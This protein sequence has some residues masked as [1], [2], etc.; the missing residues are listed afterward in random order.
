[1]L[2]LMKHKKFQNYSQ[3]YVALLMKA[4]PLTGRFILTGSSSPE[5]L[6]NI[7]ESLAGRIAIIELGTLKAN[8]YYHKPLSSFYDIFQ[9][10]LNKNSFPTTPPPLSNQEIQNF[11]FIGGY[12]EPI[13]KDQ[14]FHQEWMVDYQSTY[15]NR[16]VAKLFPR[17]NKVKVIIAAL[18]I[19]LVNFLVKLLIKAI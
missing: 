3:Y 19:C 7:S 12:P 14:V 9:S 8:E 4:V 1:M 6:K 18:L 17:L 15:I 13:L 16:D 11:W 2:S 10:P 5:L